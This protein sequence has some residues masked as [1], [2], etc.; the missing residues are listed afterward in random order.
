MRRAFRFVA[1][2]G[3]VLPA[4]AADGAR[5]IA[6]TVQVTRELR[7]EIDLTLLLDD[8]GGQRVVH[9]ARLSGGPGTPLPLTTALEGTAPLKVEIVLTPRADGAP[10]RCLLALDSS[11]R[12]RDRA[13]AEA[14]RDLPSRPGRV[15]L[16]DLWSDGARRLI[17]AIAC[18]WTDRPR[19]DPLDGTRT[20][21]ELTVELIADPDDG[22]EQLLERHR[23]RGLVGSPLTYAI[24]RNAGAA[25]LG[26]TL[27]LL[28]RSIE[29]DRVRLEIRLRGRA[30]D[31]SA[32]SL[33]VSVRESLPSGASLDLPL[34]TRGTGPRLIF[35]I[36]PIF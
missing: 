15:T 24:G 27:D 8:A 33:D 7:A 36:R 22:P 2:L 28:P 12:D 3:V 18:R 23:L 4:L 25:P 31:E 19:I 26:M 11:V 30:G 9:T 29:N 13:R 14:H 20:E 1:M 21:I 16:V 10:N 17:A 5:G 35:R 6:P 34:P 32:G